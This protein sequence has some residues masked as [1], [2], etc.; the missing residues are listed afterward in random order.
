ME[1]WELFEIWAPQESVWSSWAKPVL[2]ATPEAPKPD[3]PKPDSSPEATRLEPMRFAARSD[4]GTA[5]VVDLPGAA[6]VDAG[7][8]LAGLGYRP[9]PLFNGVSHPFAVV[10]SELIRE[11]LIAGA[12][13]L[14][15][16]RLPAGAPPA[17]LLDSKRLS[18]GTKPQPGQFDN[19]WVVFPQDFPSASFLS[20]RG[21]RRVV[22]LQETPGQPSTDLAHVL[23][24]WQRA[25]I[26][27]GGQEKGGTPQPLQVN[28]PSWFRSLFYRTFTLAGLRRN[29]AGG[30]GA[31][32]PV[33]AVSTGGG[34][35]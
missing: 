6:S 23:F 20:S 3:A 2:F 10:R 1:P 17:F 29:S 9:V 21:I 13:E 27:I 25:G 8:E 26:E 32:I 4:G 19:R 24:R 5:F 7:L 35:G 18:P 11:R 22:L 15:G 31:V 34:F 14:R 33:A 30:F 12:E 16:I 28:R